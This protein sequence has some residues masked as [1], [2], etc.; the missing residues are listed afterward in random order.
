GK[1][2][3]QRQKLKFREARDKKMGFEVTADD[4]TIEHFFGEAYTKKGKQ[5]GKT[6][7]MGSKNRRFI[8]MYGFHP[9]EY[10]LVRYVDPLTGKIIDDSIY[11]DVLLVQEQFT[12]ARREAINDDLLSN[13]KVA[14]N[15][16]IVAYFIKEGANAALKVDLTPHNPLKAC[17]RI[18]TIAGFPE[19]ESELRQ[20]GQPIQ[21]SKN[22]VPH[23][24][25]TSDSSVVTHE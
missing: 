12:K 19:R 11:T 6:T 25:E 4:G 13:E 14:Q 2:K 15:P 3:R 24:P 20:T 10:S 21:I 22:Q 8:N 7:G 18:N 9:T 17:D 23:N 16:G 5:K 1:D